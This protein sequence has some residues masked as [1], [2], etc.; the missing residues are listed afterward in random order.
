MIDEGWYSYKNLCKAADIGIQAT[1]FKYFLSDEGVLTKVINHEKN[2]FKINMNVLM[3]KDFYINK[4]CK[5]YKGQLMFDETMIQYVVNNAKK[6]KDS[7][8]VALRKAKEYTDTKSKLESINSKN[9]REEIIRICEGDK[10]K[11]YGGYKI[12]QNKYPNFFKDYELC[13][14]QNKHL[15]QYSK[16]G[17]TKLEY[18]CAF[19]KEGNYFLKII[20]E[21]YA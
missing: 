14:E 19:M 6:I 10:S 8:S 16:H 3:C 13:N 2:S 21:L 12:L 20:C 9:Y 18:I 5:V 7:Y 15:P 11:Y 1:S 4:H 17:V